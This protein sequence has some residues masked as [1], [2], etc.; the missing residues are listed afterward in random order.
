MIKKENF[1]LKTYSNYTFPSE[2]RGGTKQTYVGFKLHFETIHW[3]DTSRV[4]ENQNAQDKRGN[5]KSR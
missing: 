2:R 3:K 1:H 4:Y 5:F